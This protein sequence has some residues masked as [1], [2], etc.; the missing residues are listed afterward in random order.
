V[1][2]DSLFKA[3]KWL[4]VT[5]VV[6]VVFTLLKL[7]FSYFGIH[8]SSELFILLLIFLFL[9]ILNICF[10]KNY[11]R[12]KTKKIKFGDLEDKKISLKHFFK[13]DVILTF[14]TTF[15]VLGL[16]NFDLILVK[17]FLDPTSSSLYGLLSLFLRAVTFVF[18]PLISVAYIFFTN[19]DHKHQQKKIL[20]LFVG[21]FI[22]A[23]ILITISYIIFGNFLVLIVSKKEYLPI[24]RYLPLAGLSGLFYSLNWLF[25]QYFLS[26]ESKLSVL[27]FGAGILQ[28]VTLYFF[29]QS[30][31][32]VFYLNLSL[33][34]LLFF[35]YFFSFLFLAFKKSRNKI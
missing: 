35:S 21:F 28:V 14:L 30:Y 27:I 9:N 24:V 4:L 6:A 34:L 1:F 29:H 8:F 25:S 16:I 33:Y 31:E 10:K 22:F 18:A 19:Q 13:K 17:K 20:L 3:M 15:G 12:N 32:Q 26:K 11:F 2:Y 23:G 5:S 7:G